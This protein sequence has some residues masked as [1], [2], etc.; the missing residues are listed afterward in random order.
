MVS[1]AMLWGMKEFQPLGV[2]DD[3]HV[4]RPRPY[5]VARA[6]GIP[7]FLTEQEWKETKVWIPSDLH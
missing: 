5:T 2:Q 3:R 1:W 7:G 4:T 6:I